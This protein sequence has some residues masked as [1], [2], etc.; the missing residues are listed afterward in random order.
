MSAALEKTRTLYPRAQ[1]DLLLPIQ[2]APLFEHDPR[3]HQVVVVDTASRGLAKLWQILKASR[4]LAQ[5]RYNFIFAFHAGKTAKL[6]S[7][8]AFP[9]KLVAHNHSFFKSD[10]PSQVKLPEKNILRPAIER[11][12]L[13]FRAIGLGDSH[14]YETKLFLSREEKA[15]AEQDIAS[16]RLNGPLLTL[17][18]GAS[19]HTKCWPVERFAEVATQWVGTQNG[20]VL[21][22]TG[23]GEEALGETFMQLTKRHSQIQLIQSPSLR[24]MMALLSQANLFIG[25]DSG[26]KHMAVALGVSSITLFGPEDPYEYHPYDQVKHPILYIKGLECRKNTDPD[27]LHSWCGIRECVEYQHQCMQDIRVV[28]VLGKISSLQK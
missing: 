27:G 3:V 1:I 21:V 11:D 19:R 24:T 4:N 15:W 18:L 28:D 12:L 13:C 7:Y 6:I 2:W 26:P 22:F 20:S 5:T 10:W 14:Q 8:L 17:S 16:R 23:P 25:N 9:R